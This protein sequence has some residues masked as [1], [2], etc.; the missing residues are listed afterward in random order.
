MPPTKRKR[1][2]AKL[3]SLFSSYIRMRDKRKNS[4]RCTFC[5]KPIAC[6]FHFVTRAKHSVRWDDR[7]AVA[8]CFGCNYR[9]EFDP[10]FAIQWYIAKHGQEAY[11]ILIYDGN[12]QAKFGIGDLEALK[13]DLE[14]KLEGVLGG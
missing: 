10:H 14:K 11:D 5:F 13:A 6:C 1:L 2:V 12:R 8:S 7:N 9:Y 3:D 4:G